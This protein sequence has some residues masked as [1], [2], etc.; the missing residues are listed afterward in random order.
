MRHQDHRQGIDLL[1]G[2]KGAHTIFGEPITA[3]YE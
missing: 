1:L 3:D 2:K